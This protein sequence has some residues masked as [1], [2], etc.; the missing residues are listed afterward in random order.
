MAKF[1]MV[2][3]LN[4]ASMKEAQQSKG[5]KN[6]D[7]KIEYLNINDLIPSEKNF[8]NTEKIDD[9]KT[10]I[11]LTGL[12]QNLIVKALDNGK[13]KVIAGHRRRLAC[14]ALVA[15]GK[16]EFE[17]VPAQVLRGID[18]VRE[19]LIMLMTNSTTRQLS[20]Y[21]KTKQA[22]RMSKLLAELK[23]KENIPG[24]VRELA[25]DALKTTAAQISRYESIN[26]NLNSELMK[27]YAAGEISVTVAYETS[28]LE[29]AEQRKVLN[30][31]NKNGSIS[32]KDVKNIKDNAPMPGQQE[33]NL[34]NDLGL[35]V[36]NETKPIETKPKMETAQKGK[37]VLQ[38]IKEMDIEEMARF[39]CKCCNHNK[40]S[41]N[42]EN[43]KI[44]LSS[45]EKL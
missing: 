44:W 41:D 12:K 31:L 6:T 8:Y 38:Q 25:A 11:E 43:C 29:A 24:R 21:E 36:K 40:F 20:D 17:T 7:L 10:S 5:N 39:L 22:E 35:A 23:K 34:N 28:K 19:E 2:Q 9:L 14:L 27:G 42:V 26:K 30:K 15:E 1:N 13:Y 3:L 16:T 45:R 32:I 18:D 37:T 33:L 4:S